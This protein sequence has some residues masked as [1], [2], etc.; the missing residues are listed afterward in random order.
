MLVLRLESGINESCEKRGA[1]FVDI[2]EP[3]PVR[4]MS[5]LSLN[6]G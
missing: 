1:D 4:P 5:E 2:P 3:R 6:Q